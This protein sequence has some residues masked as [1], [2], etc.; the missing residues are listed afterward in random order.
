VLHAV[1][2]LSMTKDHGAQLNQRGAGHERS[3][4]RATATP[5]ILGGRLCSDSRPADAEAEDGTEFAEDC[6]LMAGNCSLNNCR[7]C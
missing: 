3:S 5:P 6:Q 1:K 4:R 2:I 7:R